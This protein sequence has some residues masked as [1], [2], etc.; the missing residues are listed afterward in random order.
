MQDRD[1]S[2]EQLL[3]DLAV[4][5]R[6]VA[7]LESAAARWQV[8]EDVTRRQRDLSVGLSGVSDLD[9]ALSLCIDAAM[10]ISGMEASAVF[11]AQ[12]DAS[13]SLAAY[14]SLP[15]E[16]VRRMCRLEAGSPPAALVS[17]GKPAY[18]SLLRDEIP[19]A[20]GSV[21]GGEGFLSTALIPIDCEG[22]VI[23]FFCIF[24]RTFSLVQETTRNVLETI[25]G[26]IGRA[27]TRIRAGERLRESEERY[28]TVADFTF[29]WEYW[30][31][32]NGM[33]EYMSPS[34]ERITGYSREEFLRDPSL[35]DRI[36][37][38][39]DRSLV[40]AHRCRATKRSEDAENT[41]EFRIIHRSG[42]VRWIGHACQEVYGPHG[43]HRGHRGSNRDISWRKRSEELL[44]R[45][46]R[47]KSVAELA[48]GVAHNFNNLLQVVIGCAQL[49]LTDIDGDKVDEARKHLQQILDNSVHA[50]ETVKR[51]QE[52]ARIR[53]DAAAGSGEVFDLNR[54]IRRAIDMSRYWWQ[55]G[56]RKGESEVD[57]RENLSDGCFVRGRQE[58][59]FEVLVHLIRNATEALVKGGSIEICSR[60]EGKEVLMTIRDT[61]V[62]ISADLLGKVFE[63]FWT[64]KGYQATGL[65]L[66]GSLGIV[67]QHGGDVGVESREG[68]GTVFT[69][70]L[71]LAERDEGGTRPVG[72]PGPTRALRILVIDDSE[73]VAS[74]LREGF[75]ELGHEAVAVFS[76]G[77][78]LELFEAGPFDVVISDLGM[79]GMNGWE[80]GRK[81]QEVCRAEGRPKPPFLLITGWGG[82]LDEMDR[83]SESGVDAVVEKPTDIQ[84]LMETV[85]NLLDRRH[86][87]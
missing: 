67:R 34:C 57:L 70:R 4:V 78:G 8:A 31:D 24:S 26:Q 58:E 20:L 2:R 30:I 47:L 60:V 66:S 75:T 59:M 27:V 76:G 49:A 37:H 43:Q 55:T 86:D 51:L 63:P 74:T 5:R 28:R 38:S 41:L 22:K 11:L 53:S 71:P 77:E 13:Y 17:K 40:A 18:F 16:I 52:F 85:L 1:K 23:A 61:G 12:E 50:S 9:T 81:I 36:V 82:Q 19:E 10:A 46:Q 72:G 29:D 33:V 25:A 87:S 54:V 48:G 65:G 7:K 21:V 44:E 83:R 69:V 56:A 14:R 15:E 35:M 73:V 62:G 84:R 39:E 80:V 79:P 45:A 42:E 64:T 6:R 3:R 32:E 68:Q